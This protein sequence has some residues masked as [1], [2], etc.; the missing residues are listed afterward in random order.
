[1]KKFLI[2]AAVSVA[3]L[4]G[5][6]PAHAD[7]SENVVIGILGGALGGLIIGEAIGNNNRPYYPPP[8]VVYAQPP[9]VIYEEYVEP[10]PVRCVYKKKKIYDP[11]LDEYR[12]VKKRVCYR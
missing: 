2:A 1:M 11:N 6:I 7:T 8:P 3:V 12:F 10:P 9:V 4:A 5:T